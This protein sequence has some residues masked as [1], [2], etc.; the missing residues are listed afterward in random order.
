MWDKHWCRGAV[1]R[2]SAMIP[3]MEESLQA[4]RDGGGLII[5]A[6]S[7]TIEFYQEHPARIRT[8]A[9]ASVTPPPEIRCE[10]PPLPVDATGGGCDT[11]ENPGTPNERVWTRQHPDLTIDGERDLIS[12][13]GPEVYSALT[14][15]AIER[16]VIMGVHT[17]MCV[18]NRSFAIKQMVRWGVPIVLC[19]DLTDAMYDPTC[20]PYVGHSEGTELV[21]RHIEA[22]WC[23]TV[24]SDQLLRAGGLVDAPVA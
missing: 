14:R 10:D 2:V 13:D 18:L 8:L 9:I 7:D 11:D 15:R 17:N 19:R 5:H 24:S 16:V 12:A 6:P 4:I 3:R 22:H 23:P 1:E 21:I 20:P